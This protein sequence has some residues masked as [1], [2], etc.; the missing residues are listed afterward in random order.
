MAG[1]NPVPIVLD[2]E[3]LSDA[4]MQGLAE[5]FGLETC[6]VLPATSDCDL[7]LRY[8][9]PRHEMSMCGHATLGAL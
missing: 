7:R 6:F 2:A 3:S 9:V 5:R 8:W 4:Q 1:G